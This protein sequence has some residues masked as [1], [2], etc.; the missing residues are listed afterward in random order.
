MS[1]VNVTIKRRGTSVWDTLFPKTIVDQIEGLGLVG[2]N[3]LKLTN[4][5]ATRFIK[6]NP[7][8]TISYITAETLKSEIDAA[9][10][11]HNHSLDEILG[12]NDILDDK[13][14][15]DANGKLLA[16]H[17]PEFLLSGTK[18][19][20][21]TDA[22]DLSTGNLNLDTLF[23]SI[24]GANESERRGY[25]FIVHTDCTLIDDPTTPTSV[26]QAPGDEGDYDLSDGIA[27]ES[28]DWLVYLKESGGNHLW[29]IVNNKQSLAT[30]I[31][32]GLVQISSGGIGARYNLSNVT[33]GEKVIDEKALRAVI[34][35]I[36]YA[37]DSALVNAVTGD[38]LF[39]GTFS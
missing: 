2:E 37:A 28:G 7:D 4:P 20:R 15:V 30:N 19:L 35:D 8:G 32:K 17:V 25:Y 26:V 29:G 27:I 3:I 24:P 23:T 36:H 39:E 12:L 22:G 34:K 13:A 1:D 11:I 6:T 5:G 9:S 18:F 38:L 10:I 31:S 14:G 21:T 33:N 16:A